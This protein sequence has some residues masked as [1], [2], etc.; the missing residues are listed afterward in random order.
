VRPSFLTLQERLVRS[1]AAGRV[2]GEE[3]KPP[4]C[5]QDHL[6]VFAHA[7]L[8]HAHSGGYL[9]LAKALVEVTHDKLIRRLQPQKQVVDFIAEVDF[10]HR[11]L[12]QF[13]WLRLESWVVAV[14]E[15]D[16]VLLAGGGVE[17][18]ALTGEV[19]QDATAVPEAPTRCVAP[20]IGLAEALGSS[21]HEPQDRLHAEIFA[22]V[23]ITEDSAGAS[24]QHPAEAPKPQ[25]GAKW[26]LAAGRVVVGER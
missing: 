4:R 12:L 22:L 2:G 19:A 20:A 8:G 11:K 24:F 3:A 17:A 5:L 1:H 15:F 18:M 25:H 23:R 9:L 13:G 26:R 14:M 21:Q 10:A 6:A 16:A 7:R